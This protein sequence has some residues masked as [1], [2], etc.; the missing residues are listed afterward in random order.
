MLARWNQGQSAYRVR[1]LLLILAGLPMVIVPLLNNGNKAL[2][3]L[4][5]MFVVLGLVMR[6]RA[7]SVPPNRR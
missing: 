3:T 2:V 6:R 7:Q 4:G 1:G 5:L